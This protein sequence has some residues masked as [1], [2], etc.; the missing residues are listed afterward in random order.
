MTLVLTSFTYRTQDLI[1]KAPPP[2]QGENANTTHL[3]RSHTAH[4]VVLIL[5]FAQVPGNRKQIPNSEPS[6]SKMTVSI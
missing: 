6:V 3:V 5:L 4:L 2:R 1:K